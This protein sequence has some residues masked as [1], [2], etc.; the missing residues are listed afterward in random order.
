[1][2]DISFAKPTLQQ[3]IA[4]AEANINTRIPGADARLRNSILNVLARTV[5]GQSHLLHN[6]LDWVARQAIVD[7]ADAE[8]L[9]N[10]GGVY[11]I[12]RAAAA[13]A[14]GN[15]TFTGSNGFTVPAG[16][17]LQRADGVL[18]VTTA[19]ATI[20]S[21][22]ASAA[23]EAVSGGVAGNAAAGVSLRLVAPIA[24]INSAATVAASGMT[25]GVD[26]EG[27]ESYRARILARIQAPPHGGA[28]S[29]YEQWALAVAGVTRAWV[30][31]N[32]LG[33]G[34][35]TVRF[36]R[37]TNTTP[38]PQNLV[39]HSEGL[40]ETEWAATACTVTPGG[41]IYPEPASVYSLTPS[42]AD[43]Y[44]EQE[45][46]IW[47]SGSFTFAVDV[48]GIGGARDLDIFILDDSDTVLE[49]QSVTAPDSDWATVSVTATG[50]TGNTL[51]V[52]IGGD[53]TFSTG[54]TIAATRAHVRHSSAASP[55][56]KTTDDQIVGDLIIPTE[57]DVETVLEYIADENR[58]PVTADVFV[59]SPLAVRLD[60][61][62]DNLI[63][64]TAAVRA[65]VLA[66]L[67]DLFRRDSEPGGT[68]RISKI[69]EAVS[70][71]T[72]EDSHIITSPPTDQVAAAGKMFVLGTVTF[73]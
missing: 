64:D 5:A 59:V 73:T 46:P 61:T 50:V 18:Y 7:T 26:D 21:G 69:W 20:A 29:D 72:G 37:D 9:D 65:A 55:Y 30:Y 39:L 70:I 25:G 49:S 42:G 51:K 48:Y 24:G 54:E 14:S 56:I 57:N 10:W 12:Q 31:P 44:I 40:D 11:A 43:A 6:Y 35:V 32:E 33:R 4:A 67:T 2:V 41:P 45:F 63:P 16:T 15:V 23:A 52:R 13:K 68:I 34:T 3:L 1:M 66:E 22:T 38:T 53:G 62:I 19:D 47:Q 28:K 27:D 36:V 60:I 58:A 71:A 17:E 8:N